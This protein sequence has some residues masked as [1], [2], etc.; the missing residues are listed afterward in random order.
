MSND[1]VEH[2]SL[3]W[4][5]IELL[6]LGPPDERDDFLAEPL[7]AAT[8]AVLVFLRQRCEIGREARSRVALADPRALRDVRRDLRCELP[9][10]VHLLAVPPQESQVFSDLAR[11]RL[12]SG[13]CRR[14]VGDAAE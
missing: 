10:R 3:R 8:V 7:E 4:L 6:T 12:E 11:R 2:A 5:R 9:I 1:V 13:V 14:A